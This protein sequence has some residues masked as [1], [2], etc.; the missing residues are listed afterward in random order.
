MDNLKIIETTGLIII[1]ETDKGE[2]V[3]NARELHQ[4]LESKQD[5]STWIKK[6]IEDTDAEEN[7]HYI[8]LHKKMEANNATLIEYILKLDT[9]KEM[10]M[11]ERND[12][13]RE[14]RRYFI[15]I[16]K[17]FKQNLLDSRNLSPE[18]QLL[19]GLLNQL[20]AQELATKEI[21]QEVQDMRD[22]ISLDSTSWR[23]EGHALIVK[24]AN[25]LGGSDHIKTLTNET[26]RLLEHRFGVN[27]N[28]RLINKK[29]R[30]AEEG[31][32]KSKREKLNK[33]DI[34]SEDKKLIEGYVIIA[35]ELAIKYGVA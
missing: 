31:I 24:A 35:K 33:M 32:C 23:K 21:K 3:V 19:T 34:I 12:K 5:F 26:Y 6:R 4:G 8:R 20:A 28:Q 22:V 2:K 18:L 1:Y 17:R 15:E 16:E 10:A 30:L 14:Y 27:L 25:K 29:R 9:A 7:Q 13:G 11:L